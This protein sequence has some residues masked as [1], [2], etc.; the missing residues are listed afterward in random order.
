M[1]VLGV[2][3]IKDAIS[4]FSSFQDGNCVPPTPSISNDP[5]HATFDAQRMQIQ[6]KIGDGSRGDTS[7][8]KSKMEGKSGMS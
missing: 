5:L 3:T 4:P 8:H 7:K 2:G 6:G 1:Y